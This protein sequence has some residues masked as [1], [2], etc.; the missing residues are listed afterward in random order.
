MGAGEEH[1]IGDRPVLTEIRDLEAIEMGLKLG[2][3]V[4]RLWP[5]LGLDFSNEELEAMEA[6]VAGMPKDEAADMKGLMDVAKEHLE[7]A[8]LLAEG[9]AE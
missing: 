9:K 5:K 2:M 3:P 6:E 1:R 4:E 7:A 8:K